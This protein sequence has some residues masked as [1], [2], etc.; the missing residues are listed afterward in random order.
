MI[1]NDSQREGG[2]ETQL[3]LLRSPEVASGLAWLV[4]DVEEPQPPRCLLFY[5]SNGGCMIVLKRF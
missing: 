2:C 3:L 5:L 1:P 4:V